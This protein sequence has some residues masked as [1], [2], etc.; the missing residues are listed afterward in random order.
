VIDNPADRGLA[1][2]LYVGQFGDSLWFEIQNSAVQITNDRTDLQYYFKSKLVPGA[3]FFPYRK[4]LI[5][6]KPLVDA[7]DG[8]LEGH[9]GQEERSVLGTGAA[10]IAPVICYESVYGEYNSG[11]SEKG[12]NV[13]FIMTNDG[14]WDN[15]AGHKQH[16]HYA[17]LRAI[18]QRKYIARSANM[19]NSG[20]INARG[21]VLVRNSYGEADA[22]RREVPLLTRRTFYSFYG[23]Y[24]GRLSGVAAVSILILALVSMVR[25]RGNF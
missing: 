19:G 11:Y 25:K 7:L 10:R 9:A 18:E 13:I 20:F 23:D 24:I 22:F 3:E 15:T 14:W 12:S 17:R 2:R 5:F 4:V 6:L 21:D 8:T 16:L 1:T